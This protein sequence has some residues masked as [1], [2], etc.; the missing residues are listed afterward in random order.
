MA[1]LSL[2]QGFFESII[3]KLKLSMKRA[4]L[5]RAD[6]DMSCALPP[7]FGGYTYRFH[8]QPDVWLLVKQ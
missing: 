6:A 7:N 4:M 2:R 1:D 3:R 8:L 5:E